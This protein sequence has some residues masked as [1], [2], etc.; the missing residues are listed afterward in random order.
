MMLTSRI[1]RELRD[2]IRKNAFLFYIT[3]A[4]FISY[5]NRK[6]RI[7]T[8]MFYTTNRCNSRC[9]TCHIW[10]S[11]PKKDLSLELMQDVLN[12]KVISSITNFGLE[13]GEFILHPQSRDI[14]EMLSD[15]N[16]IL[17]SN[18]ILADRLIE[19]VK[20]LNVKHIHLSLDG[21]ETTH[22][23]I[24]GIDNYD[25]VVKIIKELKGR[26]KISVVFTICPWSSL[27]DF[28]H[29]RQLC[30]K[31]N[32]RFTYSIYE[33][34]NLFDV[35]E[36]IIRENFLTENDTSGFKDYYLKF[37]KNW[38]GGKTKLPCLSI[39]NRIVIFP[40][41]DVPLCSKKNIILGNLNNNSLDEIW[42]L[43]RTKKLQ[44]EYRHCNDCWISFHRCFD[45]EY[46]QCLEHIL[47]KKYIERIISCPYEMGQDRI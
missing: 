19:T 23:N 25:K 22:R 2:L 1:N 9:K 28:I 21:N 17:L 18:G 45:L 29:V 36:N 5:M 27:E 7:L 4:F 39:A 24:R 30:D 3:N 31:Y 8:L 15:R 46:I 42:N 41:G 12:S 14:I 6:R 43:D 35:G 11:N 37:Y 34:F 32:I 10:K 20:E 40:N 44:E 33:D 26:T 47:P 16:Y 38:V 13:G